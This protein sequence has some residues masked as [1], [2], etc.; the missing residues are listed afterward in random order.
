MNYT[1]TRECHHGRHYVPGDTATETEL[2]A[3]GPIPKW[4]VPVESHA[5]AM[6]APTPLEALRR[7]ADEMGV[8]W[9]PSW[10]ETQIEHAITQAELNPPM[11]PTIE[12]Q[13]QEPGPA[14]GR[15]HDIA[16]L[17]A[18]AKELGIAAERTWKGPDYA[19]A[20]TQAEQ[21]Q[22]ADA[23]QGE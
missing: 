23:G 11:V 21:A 9:I 22:A 6:A 8:K 10:S 16:A 7:R 17:R 13:G 15:G 18:R 5:A 20:I 3:A 12:G 2:L 19:N 14:P 1:C 4:F